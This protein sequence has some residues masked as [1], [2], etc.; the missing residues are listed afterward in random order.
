[1][2]VFQCT[3]CGRYLY[4]PE[5]LTG[6][7]WQC[8]GCGPTTVVE[9]AGSVSAKLEELLDREYRLS[10]AP[11]PEVE[12]LHCSKCNRVIYRPKHLLGRAWQCSACGPTVL[13]GEPV[14][15]PPELAALRAGTAPASPDPEEEA[16]P[17]E[18]RAI[19][20]T[21]GM[22]VGA[23]GAVLLT[24]VFGFGHL[25]PQPLFYVLAG[26]AFVVAVGGF[27]VAAL[28]IPVM[29]ASEAERRRRVQDVHAR[30]NTAPPPAR[31]A[32]TEPRAPV[33]HVQLRPES[34][35]P[36]ETAGEATQLP[37]Q[38]GDDR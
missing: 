28:N 10:L 31:P 37:E 24:L 9:P 1:M 29:L 19:P 34:V 38:P 18:L 22:L 26:A 12:A 7:A 5:L 33:P 27:A 36:A 8:P 25:L 11:P 32:A 2:P 6:R 15:L 14:D 16:G 13:T 20:G 3:K 30:L 4:R 21:R 17:F 23:A 35:T